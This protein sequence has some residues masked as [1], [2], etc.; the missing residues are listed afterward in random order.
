LSQKI[1][2]EIQE[3]INEYQRCMK[4]MADAARRNKEKA[5]NVI[6]NLK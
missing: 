4:A 5:D 2:Y 6:G 1:N 3:S